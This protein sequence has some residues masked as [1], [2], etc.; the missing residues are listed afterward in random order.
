M[1]FTVLIKLVA[2]VA[3]IAVNNKQTVCTNSLVLCMRVKVL[4]LPYTKLVCCLAII[5]C[6]NYLFARQP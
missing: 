3:L 4:Q 6:F 5:A 1:F 2:A